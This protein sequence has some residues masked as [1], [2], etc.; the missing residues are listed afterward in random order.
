MKKQ[1][2]L[3]LALLTFVSALFPSTISFANSMT[4]LASTTDVFTVRLKGIALEM[5]DQITRATKID[6][7]KLAKKS[8][9]GLKMMWIKEKLHEALQSAKT[10][11][12][13]PTI[14]WTQ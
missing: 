9:Y 7:V 5:I 12:L 14:G 11:P 3:N 6:V 2:G 4:K 13:I 1:I 8:Y 10:R